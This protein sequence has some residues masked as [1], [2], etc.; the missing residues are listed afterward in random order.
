MAPQKQQR[1]T[2]PRIKTGNCS[3]K[4]KQQAKILLS[5]RTAEE[6]NRPCF[7]LLAA[8]PLVRLCWGWEGGRLLSGS[9]L[10]QLWTAAQRICRK[11]I[12]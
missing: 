6:I 4:T 7:K 2:L 1:K 11:G 8:G 10:K 9:H 3:S 5:C 12:Q